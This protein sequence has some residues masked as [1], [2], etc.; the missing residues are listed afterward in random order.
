MKQITLADRVERLGVETAFVV[1]GQAAAHAAAGNR[2]T[3]PSRGEELRVVARRRLGAANPR[4][5]PRAP[6]NRRSHFE[7][8]GDLVI[9]QTSPRLNPPSNFAFAAAP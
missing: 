7:A 1:A 3:A 2:V 9:M 4:V 6:T 8:R 5:P